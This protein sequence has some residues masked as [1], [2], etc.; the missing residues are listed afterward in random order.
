MFARV[1]V[2]TL[3]CATTANFICSKSNCWDVRSTAMVSSFLFVQTAT[4]G[5]NTPVWTYETS[6]K[7]NPYADIIAASQT[8]A[9]LIAL[10]ARAELKH[11]LQGL[12]MVHDLVREFDTVQIFRGSVEL[13]RIINT[14]GMATGM[15][16]QVEIN[17]YR[18]TL[19]FS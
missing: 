12:E 8:N 2:A 16:V 7:T 10:H 14:G 3:L 1:V 17:D 13:L 4:L 11:M 5:K 18:R 19:Y 15:G 6:L 9:K